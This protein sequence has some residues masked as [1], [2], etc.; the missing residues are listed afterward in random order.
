MKH[1]L[2][3]A[4]ATSL[5]VSCTSGAFAS[6]L[7]YQPINPK[8]GGDPLNGSWLLSQGQSQ[9]EN[10]GGG[11]SFSIDFPE[12]GGLDQTDNTQQDL[13]PV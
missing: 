5:I 9:T 3:L 2:I 1:K 4:L 7:V 12:F 6:S 13:P 11:S 10:A 8:F